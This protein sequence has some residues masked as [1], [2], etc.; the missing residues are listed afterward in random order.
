[1]EWKTNLNMNVVCTE[2]GIAKKIYENVN[3]QTA[4]E[5]TEIHRMQNTD[6]HR[7]FNITI[8]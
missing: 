7:T 2:R 6:R 1:M 8:H 3:M 4:S 5:L